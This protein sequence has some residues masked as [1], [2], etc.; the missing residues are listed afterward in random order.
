M[1]FL[2]SQNVYKNMGQLLSSAK[3]M[4]LSKSH[5]TKYCCVYPYFIRQTS[6]TLFPVKMCSLDWLWFTESPGKRLVTSLFLNVY[7]KT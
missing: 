4:F 1:A 3:L 7:I 5:H 2:M 6:V